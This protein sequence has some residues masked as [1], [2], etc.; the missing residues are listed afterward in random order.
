L[1]NCGPNA[2]Q[3]V[4]V[5]LRKTVSGTPVDKYLRPQGHYPILLSKAT[6][7]GLTKEIYIRIECQSKAHEVTSRRYWL[8]IDGY[9]KTNLKLDDVH[10][11]VSWEKGR[12]LIA[13]ATNSDGNITRRY[14]TRFR[15]QDEGSRDVVVVLEFNIAG[16]RPQARCHVMTL[17]RDTP[18][19]DL[20]QKLMYMRLE[21]FMKQTTN[22]GD[23]N[24][25]VAVEE[26]LVAQEPMLV[27]RLAR[28]SSMSKTTVDANWELQ[29]VDQKLEFLKLLQQEDQI[30]LEAEQLGQQWNEKKATS[31][32]M[33][34]RLV[35]VNQNLEKLKEEQ[36]SLEE[37]QS[38]LEYGLEEGVRDVEQLTKRHKEIL[39]QKD[40][41]L[42]R[43]S[44]I[45]QHLDEHETK[46][47]PGNWL[48]T[49]I[50]MHFDAGKIGRGLKDV[51]D[52]DSSR[53][54]LSRAAESGHNIDGQTLLSWAASKGYVAMAG[55]L[56]EKGAD[57]EA[58]SNGGCT[59]LGVAARYGHEA[60]ARLLLETGADINAKCNLGLSPLGAAARHGH[61]AVA[62]LLIEKGADIEAKSKIGRSPL[63]IATDKG[64]AAIVQLLLQKGANIKVEDNHGNT[65]LMIAT[66]RG[67]KAVEQL[68]LDEQ[69][70]LE[71]Q[72]F[73]DEQLLLGG[74]RLGR[75]RDA[76]LMRRI[77]ATRRGQDDYGTQ[78]GGNSLP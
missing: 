55:L 73:L 62:R 11:P 1:L 70:L 16:L 43:E 35:V 48:E 18:L 66:Y 52:L 75:L 53:P 40:G 26:R 68:L 3:V 20:S 8:R 67:H 69:Q 9:Q 17:S 59:P 7:V 24:V 31:D 19:E 57:I 56:L 60:V 65:P 34:E 64:H 25:E 72:L 15:T 78:S 58:K 50:K 5:P 27:V 30:S 54:Q 44:K 63:R 71:E 39:E 23:L 22:D 77:R 21:A 49:V 37:E 32:E 2:E 29:Q 61:K 36:R 10:P 41:L 12:A 6:S 47:G 74:K 76:T 45:Q 33:R 14:L 28:S 13:K 46:E 4:G 38:L 51:G 42:G